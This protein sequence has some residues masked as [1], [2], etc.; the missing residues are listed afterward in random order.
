[1]NKYPNRGRGRETDSV[2]PFREQMIFLTYLRV[3]PRYACQA[4][5]KV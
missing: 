3:N 4:I 5:D 1:M 2:S